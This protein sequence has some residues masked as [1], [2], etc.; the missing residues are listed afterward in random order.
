[1]ADGLLVVRQ[2]AVGTPSQL[3]DW[4]GSSPQPVNKANA[5][6]AAVVVIAPSPTPGDTKAVSRRFRRPCPAAKEGV[7]EGRSPCVSDPTSR[8]TPWRRGDR[9]MEA[10]VQERQDRQD[11]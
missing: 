11:L 5:M 8:R 2:S 9:G 1:M 3:S 7:A 4:P 6:T 10:T